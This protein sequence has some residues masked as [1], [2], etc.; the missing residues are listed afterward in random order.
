MDG[1]PK[2]RQPAKAEAGEQDLPPCTRPSVVS[3]QTPGY[4]RCV[5]GDEKEVAGLAGR[6][7]YEAARLSGSRDQP[8]P[9]QDSC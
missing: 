8:A 3:Q 2:V 6:L 4:E 9:D 5:G 7:W 1:G